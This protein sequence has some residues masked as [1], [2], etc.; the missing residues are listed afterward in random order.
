[1]FIQEIVAGFLEQ[2]EPILT[3]F[4]L[5]FQD[6]LS[7]LVK[8]FH[9]RILKKNALCRSSLEFFWSASQ[10]FSQLFLWF[11]KKQFSPCFFRLIFTNN[12]SLQEFLSEPL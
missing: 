6:F 12:S 9:K 11:S 4:F 2:F 3:R 5:V 10:D 1:M 7:T 8:M